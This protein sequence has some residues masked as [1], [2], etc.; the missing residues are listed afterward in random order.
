[1]D[2]VHRFVGDDEFRF[3][4]TG[5]VNESFIRVSRGC[6]DRSWIICYNRVIITKQE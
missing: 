6:V 1:L 5:K 2:Q 4:L 3:H